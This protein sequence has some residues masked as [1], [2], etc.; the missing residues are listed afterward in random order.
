MAKNDKDFRKM[1][2]NAKRALEMEHERLI[3]Q[4]ELFDACLKL[5]DIMDK[6]MDENEQL[7]KT[8]EEYQQ[9]LNEEKQQRAALEMK[10]AETNKLT[11][12]TI[13]A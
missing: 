1:A 12:G 2:Q 5:M 6:V 4:K 7:R 3:K 13:T 10:L 9:Q 11:A 8:V